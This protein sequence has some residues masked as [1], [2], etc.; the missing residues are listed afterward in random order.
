[1]APKVSTANPVEIIKIHS[2]DI[3]LR[4]SVRRMGIFGSM[5][6]GDSKASSDLDILIDMETPTFDGYMDLKFFL[7]D[8]TGR[9]IDLVLDS[10]LKPRLRRQ[11]EREIIYV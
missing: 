9:D 4:F 8:L 3:Q 2:R 6:R 11:I 10:A 7:E 5:A 1:M